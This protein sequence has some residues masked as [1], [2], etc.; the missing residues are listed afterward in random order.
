M[1]KIH[2][3]FRDSTRHATTVAKN[4][5]YYSSTAVYAAEASCYERKIIN[6]WETEPS[7]EEPVRW[8]IRPCLMIQNMLICFKRKDGEL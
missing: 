3:V 5:D 6:N 8:K 4:A 2:I 1:G 7:P